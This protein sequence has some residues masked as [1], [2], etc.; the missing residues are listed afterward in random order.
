[1][2]LAA[3]AGCR[4]DSDEEQGEVRPV[5]VLTLDKSVR[6]DVFQL[7]G[8]VQAQ[9]EVNLS[10]RIGGRLADRLVDVGDVVR[11]GQ[12]IARLETQ[13]EESGMQSARAQLNAARALQ[14]EAS[15]NFVRMR[16]LVA[17]NAVSRALF[18]QAQANR[19]AA[20]SQVESAQAQLN[21]AENRLGYTRLVSDVGGVVTS[22]GAEPG[23]VV[24]AGRMIVQIAGEDARDAVFDVPARIK[25]NAARNA[26]VEVLLTADPKVRTSGR[27]REVS[28]RA[29]PMTGTFRVRVSLADPPP[30][31]RLGTTVTGRLPLSATVGIAVPTTAVMR[32]GR[33][34]AVWVVDPKV[35]TVSM[36]VIRIQSS[37]PYEVVV[38]S[39]LNAG[40]TVVTAGVQAL[41][42]GQKVRPLEAAR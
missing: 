21:L 28:P 42:P 39:G 6:G 20:D 37:D 31:M 38:A 3:L 16:D 2:A 14:V 11:P 36:R 30:A 34:P 27:V 18:D 5:R 8:N 26:T 41:R 13:D 17:Q 33:E 35:K 12:L 9:R 24:S 23:E 7:V 32:S 19:R 22:Q 15:N 10:F 4:R 1:M 29:D 25:D 40:D